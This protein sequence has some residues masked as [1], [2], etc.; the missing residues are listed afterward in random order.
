LNVF[1]ANGAR[2]TVPHKHSEF[3][4]ANLFICERGTIMFTKLFIFAP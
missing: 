1:V 2:T 3:Y 4:A